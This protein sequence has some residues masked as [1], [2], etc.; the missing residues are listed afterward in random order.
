M[1][2]PTSPPHR[3]GVGGQNYISVFCFWVFGVFMCFISNNQKSVFGFF[4]FLVCVCVF[5]CFGVFWFFVGLFFFVFVFLCFLFFFVFFCVFDFCLCF[6]CFWAFC[7][8][9]CFCVFLWI[10]GFDC[11]YFNLFYVFCYLY[12]RPI[13]TDER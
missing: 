4:G 3:G 1:P 2:P 6:F 8:F 10:G 13:S 5:F 7:C 12:N 9:Y 11:I